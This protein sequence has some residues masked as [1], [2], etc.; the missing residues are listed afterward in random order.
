M[1]VEAHAASG[2]AM[3]LVLGSMEKLNRLM[4]RTRAWQA[5]FLWSLCL[6]LY[7]CNE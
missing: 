4:A 7:G 6:L 3:P 5:R 2:G 1:E